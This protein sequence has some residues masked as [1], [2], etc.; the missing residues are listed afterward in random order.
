MQELELEL[1]SLQTKRLQLETGIRNDIQSIR[2]GLRPLKVAGRIFSGFIR[3][4]AGHDD[5]LARGL[6][7]GAQM[8]SKKYLMKNLSPILRN[9]LSK[10]VENITVN[11]SSSKTTPVASYLSNLVKSF[12]YRKSGEYNTEA[13]VT[14]ASETR[15]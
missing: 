14:A 3:K 11:L 9:V 10:V 13:E 4:Q 15:L 7:L 8:L 12:F 1:Q 6:G 5:I 2:D